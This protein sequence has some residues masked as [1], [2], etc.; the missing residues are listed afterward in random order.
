MNRRQ[1][2]DQSWIDPDLAALNLSYPEKAGL[3]VYRNY[4]TKFEEFAI[5]HFIEQIDKESLPLDD[6]ERLLGHIVSEEARFLPVI[7]C[8]FADDVL[9][10]AFK[11]RLPDG[12]PGGRSRMLG[13]Y[14]A[15][16][17]FAKRIQLAYAFDVLS[18]DLMLE[19]DMLRS[20]RNKISH[21]W[22][23]PDLEK[24]LATVPLNRMH[25]MEEMLAPPFGLPEA[26]ANGSKPIEAFRI[27]LAWISARLVYEAAA[28]DRA[29][30]ARLTPYKV[31]YGETKPLW[32]RGVAKLAAKATAEIT[33]NET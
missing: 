26:F 7:V 12:I 23:I 9:K 1:A 20:V 24:L 15:L 22:T 21:S 2:E 14:G 19:L 18:R 16:S 5:K 25:K 31:L 11:E 6:L 27:R 4:S 33:R 29:K 13:G 30:A 28:Y 8:A 17:D 32:L 3:Q 10:A